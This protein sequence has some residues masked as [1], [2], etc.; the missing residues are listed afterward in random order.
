M[1]ITVEKIADALEISP[2]YLAR[3]F[4]E[5]EGISVKKY[6]LTERL[7]ISCNLLRNSDA[8]IAEISDYLNFHSQSY[9]TEKFKQQYAMTPTQYRKQY[10]RF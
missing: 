6:L 2:S 7:K 5:E 4:K 1:K 3:V 8:S 10:K 9:Y